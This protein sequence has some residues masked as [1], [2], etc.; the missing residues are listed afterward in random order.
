[1]EHE[2]SWFNLLP[3]FEALEHGLNEQFKGWLFG[4]PIHLQHVFAAGLATL[5]VFIASMM[6]RSS[7]AQAKDGGLVPDDKVSVRNLIEIAFEK[8]YG[9]AE[10]IIGK[11]VD[12]FFP[13]LA[14]LTLFIFFSNI[15]G[16][17][18]GFIP[19]TDNWNTTFMCAIFVFFYFN[20]HGLRKN[21]IQYVLHL[22]NPTGEWN[23]VT[24]ALAPLIFVIEVVGLLARPFSLGVRLATNMVVDHAVLAAFLGLVPILIPVIFLG[25]GLLVSLIQTVVFVLLTM[26][27]IGG[28]VADMHHHDHA[29][30]H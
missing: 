6:A 19:P 28:A 11:E 8:V 21:G 13:V 29:E 16:L 5:V 17:I 3:F 1:M 10:Q 9:M 30:A 4:N 2:T 20:F 18:P 7:M 26:I 12:R 15:L 22:A 27:Y 24:I 14:T 23:A 25:L